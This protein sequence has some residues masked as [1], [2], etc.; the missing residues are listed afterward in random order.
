MKCFARKVL[1]WQ[2]ERKKNV[3]PIFSLNW[4]SNGFATLILST[5]IFKAELYDVHDSSFPGF[6]AENFSVSN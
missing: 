5:E 6:I 1:I 3:T 2:M 4:K